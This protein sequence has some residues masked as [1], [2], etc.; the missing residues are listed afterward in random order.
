[1][2]ENLAKPEPSQLA[3]ECVKL[4][5]AIEKVLAEEGLFVDATEWPEY[6]SEPD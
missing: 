3:Q 1:M 4:D 6:S 5:P 2:E